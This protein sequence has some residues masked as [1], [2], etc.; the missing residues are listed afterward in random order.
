MS[1]EKREQKVENYEFD[2]VS[3]ILSYPPNSF[4][5]TSHS[6]HLSTS[7][8]HFNFLSFAQCSVAV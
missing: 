2:K 4:V 7:A 6:V 5:A 3:K 8:P 1:K